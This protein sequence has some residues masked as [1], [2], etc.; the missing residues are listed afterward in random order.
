MLIACC[1]DVITLHEMLIASC[2]DVITL[3]EMLIAS[4]SDVLKIENKIT[5]NWSTSKST[6]KI[7]NIRFVKFYLEFLITEMATTE[8]DDNVGPV[9]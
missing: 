8:P 3:H 5:H 6:T 1:L 4:C 2:S 7:G 9:S